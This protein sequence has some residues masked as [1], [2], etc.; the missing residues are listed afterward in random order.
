MS[1]QDRLLDSL[2][3]CCQGVADLR[4]GQTTTYAMAD[5]AVAAFAPF[6]MQCPSFLAHQRYLET[7]QG[8]SNCE[9]LLGIRK[10]AYALFSAT[11]AC[12]IS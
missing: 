8:R 3:C 2:R 12:Y 10:P 9:T 6:F 5:F 4:R 7:G 1:L 11:R